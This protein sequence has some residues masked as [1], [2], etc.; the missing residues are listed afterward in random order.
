MMGER[1]VRLLWVSVSA[2]GLVFAV[3]NW[4]DAALDRRAVGQLSDFRPDGP[5]AIAG[6]ANVRRQQ[7]RALTQACCL[8]VGVTSLIAEPPLSP[9]LRGWTI[10]G[11]MAAQV[12]AVLNDLL[13]RNDRRR[14]IEAPGFHP[15]RRKTD[16][17]S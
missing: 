10:L 3:L 16:R 1:A 5:R 15:R 4:R 13:D 2:A 9:K 8:A 17:E 14:T 11:L 6:R 7:L 12:G